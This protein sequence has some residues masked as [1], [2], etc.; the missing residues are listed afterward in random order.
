[1]FNKVAGS[2]YAGLLFAYRPTFANNG[3]GYFHRRKLEFLFF[4][5]LVPS[6]SSLAPLGYFRLLPPHRQFR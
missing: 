5:L 1:M 2:G 6:G 4:L 3:S